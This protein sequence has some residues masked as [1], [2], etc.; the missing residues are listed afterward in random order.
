MRTIGLA[1][2]LTLNLALLP[3][4]AEAQEDPPRGGRVKANGTPRR[5]RS[6]AD[7]ALTT[8]AEL[9]ITP[10]LTHEWASFLL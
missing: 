6:L 1:V 10:T 3:F 8:G 9:R 7:G 2:V 4:A 5:P